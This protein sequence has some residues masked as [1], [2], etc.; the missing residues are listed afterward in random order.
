VASPS[1]I[2]AAPDGRSLA[3]YEGGD[4]NGVPV[5]AHH[6]TPGAGLL[7]GPHARDAAGR[8]IR[9]IGYDR[10]GYGGSAPH[11]GRTIADAAADVAA[12]S[13]ALGLDRI[14]TWGISGGGPHALACAALLPDRVA[15]AASIAGIAPYDAEG[16]DWLAGMGEGNVAEFGATLAGRATLAPLLDE[17]AAGMLAGT[18][19]QLR[20]ALE[21]LLSPADSAVL[22]GELA[23]YFHETVALGIGERRDGWID[24]DLAFAAPWGFDP[25]AIGVPVTVWQGREDRFVPFAHGEWLAARI[26]GIEAHL[27]VEDGHLTLAER[28]VP[29]VHAWLLDR[30]RAAT[31]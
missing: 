2:V 8:G 21:T 24:D 5:V 26:P 18:P 16:L 29:E 30:F 19:E 7:Y 28:R 9:L 10:P 12:I 27:S 6:G 22:T 23:A 31:A 4:P 15:A 25:A 11:P 17:E 13:D 14:C 3:V 1:V 20:D